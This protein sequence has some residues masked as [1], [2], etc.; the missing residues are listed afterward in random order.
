MLRHVWVVDG[1]LLRAREVT[2][3][4]SD[5]RFTEML[6]GNLGEG[7]VLVIGEQPKS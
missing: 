1:K 5:S 7:E 6:E 4:I 2:L 3:G